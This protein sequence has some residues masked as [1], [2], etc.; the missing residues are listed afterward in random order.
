MIYLDHAAST[1][2]FAELADLVGELTA[3]AYAN[4]SG[5]HAA[6]REAS[7]LVEGARESVATAVGCSPSEVIFT[8]GGSESDNLAVKGISWSKVAEGRHIVVS[9]VEHHAVLDA[10]S[11]LEGRGFEVDRAPVD[12]DCRVD[13]DA[14]VG[15]C[16]PD[17]TLV[18]VMLV[19]NEVGAIEP[20]GDIAAAV[21]EVAP[22]AVIHTD[23]S[24][25]I[26][27]LPVNLADLGVDAITLSG[28]KFGAPHGVGALVLK[29]GVGIEPLIHGGGQ[30]LSR[31]AGTSP[32]P[33][34]AAFG[35]GIELAA[36]RRQ[37]SV[38]R[39]RDMSE[40]LERALESE[41]DG[42]TINASGADR[43]PN[44]VS[45]AIDA[46]RS[47]DTLILLDR[48]GVSASA[49]SSCASGSLEVSHVLRAMGQSD[50]MA[51][52]ALRVSIGR[53][54]SESEI[55]LGAKAIAAAVQEQR[56]GSS[57]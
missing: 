11:W 24:Q 12:R 54:T 3:S 35:A 32:V 46:T 18:S 33:Q 5:M 30:E 56:R 50:S 10:A 48:E 25:A 27:T 44:I 53:D 26:S 7:A 2:V 34:I 31:R 42:L 55:D 57:R 17:T 6:S 8:S 1:P 43:V 39:M 38:T 37:E 22:A 23:A 49:G 36:G 51:R 52:T 16:R 20:V 15:L 21:R 45:L 19:N 9:S 13:L 4:P 29:D 41:I 40:R 47:E 28:H 14:L